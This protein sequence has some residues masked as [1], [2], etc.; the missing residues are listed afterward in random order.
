MATCVSFA[1][2]TGDD[3]RVCGRLL[4]EQLETDAGRVG[5]LS[6]SGMQLET[7]QSLKGR[8]GETIELTLG[9]DDEQTTVKG[10]IVWARRAGFRRH[11]VGIRFVELAETE[12]LTL[13]RLAQSAIFAPGLGNQNVSRRSSRAA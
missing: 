4:T 6:A 9:S 3:R 1:R 7:R 11:V 2:S 13:T 10:E 12:R 5:N 8:V